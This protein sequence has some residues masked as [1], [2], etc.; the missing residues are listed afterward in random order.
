[1][2]STLTFSP[3]IPRTLSAIIENVFYF[4]R[5]V[6]TSM[7]IISDFKAA[8]RFVSSAQLKSAKLK[9]GRLNAAAY[10]RVSTDHAE[11]ENSFALQKQYFTKLISGDPNLN[12]VGI[13]SDLGASGTDI[14]G[15]L[16]LKRLL[17]SCQDGFIDRI[18]CK[19]ISRFARNTAD[20]IAALND[21]GKCGVSVFFEK[22][23]LDTANSA[24]EF[25]LTTLG[26]VAQEESRSIS[27]NIKVGNKMRFS[28]GEVCNYELYG[29]RFNGRYITTASGYKYKD[30]DIIDEEAAIVRRIFQEAAE[31]CSYTNIA[32]RLNI[33]DVPS[34]A[35]GTQ[36]GYWTGRLISQILSRERYTG[37]VLIQKRFV[38]SHLDHAAIKNTGQLDRFLIK[39]HHPAII[40]RELFYKV[41]RLRR[42]Q[43]GCGQRH[44]LSHMLICGKCGSYLHSRNADNGRIWYCPT[45]ERSCGINI[46][47]GLKISESVVISTIKTAAESFIRRF[48][49]AEH[50]VGHLSQKLGDIQNRDIARTDMPPTIR[51]AFEKSYNDRENAIKWLCELKSVLAND[52]DINDKLLNGILSEHFKAFILCAEIQKDCIKLYRCD[53]ENSTLSIAPGLISSAN[54]AYFYLPNSK[55]HNCTDK[56]SE[57]KG[58]DKGGKFMKGTA[59]VEVIPATKTAVRVGGQLRDQKELRVCAYCRV[60]TGDDSQQTSYAT[61]KAFY[62]DL[63]KHKRGWQFAGIYADEALSGTSRKH[64]A[65]FNRMIE[66]AKAGKLDYIVAKSISRFARNTVD[67]LTCIRE[68]RQLSPPVG[69]FFEKENIDTLD[70]KG[71]LI[72]TIL[73]ALAQDESRSIS[74]NIRWSIQKN[75]QAGKPQINLNRMLGY[76]NGENGEWVIDQKQ[77]EIVRYIFSRYI[78]GTSANKIAGE[79]NRLGK[80]TVNGN[81]WRADSVLLI[82]RNE[83]YV[84]DIEMQKTV[85]ID[86]LTHRSTKNNG[87]APKY[88][89]KDHHAGI[90]DRVTWEKVKAMLYEP[91]AAGN[92]RHQR[93]N[94][95]VFTNISWAGEKLRRIT[96]SAVAKGY[97]DGRSIAST[98]ANKS[99]FGEKYSFSYPVWKVKSR[100]P[101]HQCAIEQSFMEELHKLKTEFIKYGYNCP[102]CEDFKRTC[103]QIKREGKD[104]KLDNY[105]KNFDLFVTCLN[106]LPDLPPKRLIPFERGIYCAFIKSGRVT[107]QGEIEYETNFG[108]QIKTHGNGRKLA[109]FIG[110]TKQHPDGQ[111][112][113]I[114]ATYQIYGNSIQYRRFPLGGK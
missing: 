58:S 23:N 13:Y 99:L 38:E 4:D 52:S 40:S 48:E 103:E 18:F 83:K 78:G 5:S 95:S 84:G 80:V 17:R 14:D 2:R 7:N 11:Q 60:S 91:T 28:R 32:R 106:S 41:Q 89:I 113:T 9:S 10:I 94:S 54:K 90:I 33:E 30:I 75:F 67:T 16:G 110:F 97:T 8:P 69:V 45:A 37:D 70:A 102:L 82:L 104:G 35:K 36:S 86:F 88:Y 53:G 26:A 12:F 46:C 68:L 107:G 109:D 76:N 27:E 19:S 57:N 34:P 63:I 74:D 77:A 101:L 1:M 81:K 21:L 65:E 112:V 47:S 111:I 43:V 96:Y 6:A 51:K 93:A 105:A 22:E 3:Y 100:T 92:G 50:C 59:S 29:Y 114:T 79:L 72:L 62:S 108:T 56:K 85:T 98:G 66:D 20:L 24:S 42:K 61:Q 87:E 25:I 71:E 64:R 39:D 31:R 55:A 49:S 73:S 15:R 44:T